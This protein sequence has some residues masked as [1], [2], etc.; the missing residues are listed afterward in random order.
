VG[1]DVEIRGGVK[2][3]DLLNCS[4]EEIYI[5]ARDI[6]TSGMKRGGKFIMAEANDLAP[7]VP[8]QN[9]EAMYAATKEFGTYRLG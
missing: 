9:L 4:S 5:K 1:D 8:L 3:P 6:L 7:C 2:V